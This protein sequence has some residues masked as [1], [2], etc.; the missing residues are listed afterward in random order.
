MCEPKVSI[1]LTTY[2]SLNNLEQTYS[3]II[4]QDYS[5]IEIVVV[6]GGSVDGTIERL[7]EYE[8]IKKYQL[9][10]ISETDHG[11][12]DA[13]NKGLK[14]A[15]GDLLLFFNDI[16]SNNS[17]ISMLASAVISNEKYIGA[18]GDLF[19]YQNGKIRRQ[20]KMGKGYIEEW[21]M[22][23][24]PTLLLRREIFNIYGGF[25]TDY[26]CAADY[27]FMVRVLKGNADKLI[28]IPEVLV[29][30]FYGGTS[31][32]GIKA[33]CTSFFEACRALKENN[34]SRPYLVSLKRTI[35]VLRQF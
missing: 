21:W 4:T 8:K 34:I 28:Y 29:H 18:H 24:H 23:A 20:W 6:D 31:S 25:K 9:V 26:K 22:P 5:N 30:M 10:W 2:N 11:I 3:S 33:Y 16:F 17:V 32:N 1:I 35:K 14:I 27:E 12:Y 7:K 19:Y 13:M 15:T